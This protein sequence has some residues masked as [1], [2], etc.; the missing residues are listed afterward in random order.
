MHHRVVDDNPLEASIIE[1]LDQHN[2]S[3]SPDVAHKLRINRKAVL[4]HYSGQNFIQRQLVQF[5]WKPVIATAFSIALLMGILF[6]LNSTEEYV[7]PEIME[8]LVTEDQLELLEQLEFYEWL[9]KEEQRQ[10]SSVK[11]TFNSEIS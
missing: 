2:D 11:Q 3:L 10:D 4:K 7:E 5:H 9:N 6:Q 8:L 1:Q